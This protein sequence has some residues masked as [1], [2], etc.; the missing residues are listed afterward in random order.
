MRLRLADINFQAGYLVAYGK[1]ASSAWCPSGEVA[2]VSLRHYVE[3]VRAEFLRG[4]RG[5]ADVRP[6]GAAGRCS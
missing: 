4:S 2:L 5:G 3:T 1:G 6:T